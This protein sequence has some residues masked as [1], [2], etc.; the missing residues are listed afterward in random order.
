MSKS[1]INKIEFLQ[2]YPLL[3]DVFPIP[4]AATKNVPDWWRS[5]VSIFGEN[6]NVPENGTL[7]LTVKKCQAFFDAMACGYMLKMPVDIY[8]DTTE[9]K[10]EI[11]LPVEL[12]KFRNELI[13]SHSTEQIS[14]MPFDKNRYCNQI[15]R[16]HPTWI[17]RTPDGYST[18]FTNPMHQPPTPLNGVEAIIDTDKMFSDGHLSF[19]I[20]KNF[21]GVLK[22]GTQLMQ[23]IPFKREEWEMSVNKDF[24]PKEL[25]I[26]RRILRSTFQNGYRM[27]FWQKKIF[28]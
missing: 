22:Q 20:E 9:N 1:N 4:E 7:K 6:P 16:I 8:I 28:K 19:L 27:K 15:L 25:D 10:F 23:V 11:Q 3:A 26:Q 13:S 21:K 14:S 2:A 17:I 5:Q 12:Q 24:P 18:L